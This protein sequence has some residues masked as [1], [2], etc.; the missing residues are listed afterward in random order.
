MDYDK[1]T[2]LPL[3]KT[4]IARAVQF[5]KYNKDVFNINPDKII[6]VGSS[7]GAGLSVLTSL[8]ES[9]DEYSDVLSDRISSSVNGVWVH[10]AQTSFSPSWYTSTFMLDDSNSYKAF[11]PYMLQD[12]DLN[13]YGH[14]IGDVTPKSP[15]IVLTYNTKIIDYLFSVQDI[16]DGYVDRLH[17]ANFGRELMRSYDDQG[18]GHRLDLRTDLLSIGE[19]KFQGFKSFVDSL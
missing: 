8:N 6:L 9:L 2:L 11:F 3:S 16:R 10:E 17:V 1:D 7:R 19:S 5:F 4:D 18:I 13:I 12:I 14:A 15:P